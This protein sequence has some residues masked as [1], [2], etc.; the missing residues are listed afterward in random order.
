MS[1]L[2]AA[3]Q[4]EK[5]QMIGERLFP[6]VQEHQPKMAGKITGMLL[7]LNNGELLNMLD[8]PDLLKD[9]MEEAV[10]VLQ[11]VANQPDQVI[12]RAS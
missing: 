7:E 8:S 5:K 2:A 11:A 1:A 6:L 4:S 3:S 12:S 10:T 9:K